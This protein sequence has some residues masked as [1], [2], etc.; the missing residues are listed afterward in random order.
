MKNKKCRKITRWKVKSP[1]YEIGRDGFTLKDIKEVINDF[2]E[3]IDANLIK[4][5][6][7]DLVKIKTKEKKLKSAWWNGIGWEGIKLKSEELVLYWKM[8]NEGREYAS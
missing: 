6:P 3:W 8:E 2:D 4:P 1:P 7:Y 5:F